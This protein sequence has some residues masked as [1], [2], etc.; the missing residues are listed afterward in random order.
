MKRLLS[1]IS[2][3]VVV[4]ILFS[5][6]LYYSR[7]KSAF[8]IE[9]LSDYQDYNLYSIDIEYDYDLDEIINMGISSDQS[10]I[11]NII[12]AVLPGLPVKIRIPDFGCS[13]FNMHNSVNNHNLMGRNYDFKRNTSAMLVRCTPKNGYSSIALSALENMGANN[14]DSC[15]KNR[16]ASLASP[17]ACLDG[18]NEKGVSISVLMLDS[19]PT[20]QSSG[21]PC[22]TTC[23][24][25]RMVLDRASTTEE[26]IDILRHF[27]MFASA[28]GDYHFYINDASGNGKIVE[29]NPHSS[30]RDMVVTKT[31]VVTN[32]YIMFK[33][34]VQSDSI[35][36]LYNHGRDRFD[37]I[38]SVFTC[39]KDNITEQVGW[40]ALIVASKPFNPL[41]KT[42]NTQWSSLY[43]NSDCS[44]S[45]VLRRDWNNIFRFSINKIPK[46]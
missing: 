11:D 23:L 18:I 21:K 19:K 9:K 30:S 12:G 45:V 28:N 46:K 33:D 31:S 42:S 5:I 13:S 44:M 3:I 8:T 37:K 1:V 6:S 25:I 27:D 39:N 29:Y 2:I 41:E 15:L 24:A 4:F 22:I 16:F 35:K 20:R 7:I 14:A 10:Y 43:D 26:A 17:F 32:F 38:D 36:G 34:S 40:N